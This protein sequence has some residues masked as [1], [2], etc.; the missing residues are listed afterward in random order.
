MVEQFQFICLYCRIEFFF[1]FF[2]WRFCQLQL[3]GADYD[4]CLFW[5][6]Y[7]C[8]GVSVCGRASVCEGS[9]STSVEMCV[10]EYV[11]ACVLRNAFVH[12]RVYDS[13]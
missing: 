1:F 5:S 8:S 11:R 9:D 2:T 13:A 10:F 3:W 6:V 12:L 7:L 4:D